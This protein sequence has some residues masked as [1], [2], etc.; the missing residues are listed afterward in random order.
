MVVRRYAGTSQSYVTPLFPWRRKDYCW[1]VAAPGD[2]KDDKCTTGSIGR[3]R[4]DV[5]VLS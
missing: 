2:D 5:V 4:T 1:F 3:H